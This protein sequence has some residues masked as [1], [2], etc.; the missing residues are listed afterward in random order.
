MADLPC[1]SQQQV[2]K[3]SV[4]D[5]SRFVHPDKEIWLK[6]IATKV[7]RQE[8]IDSAQLCA[9]YDQLLDNAKAY[10]SPGS[11]SLGTPGRH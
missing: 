6:K 5:Y 7:R 10:N 8:Y 3:A 4:P 11:G 9:D 1:A 2:N